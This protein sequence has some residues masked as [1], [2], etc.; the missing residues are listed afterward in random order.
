MKKKKD[1]RVIRTHQLLRK[2]LIELMEERDLE[3]ITVQEIAERATIKRATFYLHFEDKQALVHQYVDEILTELSESII[4][5]MNKSS[6]H[7]DIHA[8]KVH[9]NF[10]KLFHHITDNYNLFYALLVRN[11]VAYFVTK[12]GSVIHD[13][14]LSGINWTEPNDTNLTAPREVIIKFVESAFLEVI[15]WWIENNRP[16]SEEEIAT[17]LLNLS[18]LGPY[19]HIPQRSGGG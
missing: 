15:V 12:L 8:G 9:P 14:I 10:L 6:E 7:F 18:V 3:Q 11:R 2:A 1:P 16:Y 13:F 4:V 5:P 19:K 17:H